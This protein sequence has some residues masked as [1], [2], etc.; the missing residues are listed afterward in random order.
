MLDQSLSTTQDDSIFDPDSRAQTLAQLAEAAA[1]SGDHNQAEALTEQITDPG[2]RARTLAQLAETATISG[3]HNRAARLASKAEALAEQLADPR[4][5]A[6][7][8]AQLAGTLV[9]T[10][11][12]TSPAPGHASSRSP[13]MVRA[14]H[15]LAAAL[16]TGSW[17]E[18]IA[19]LAR[20]DPLAVTALADELQVRWEPNPHGTRDGRGR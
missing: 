6:Q 11:E 9:E 10:S 8:L 12:K 14:R 15:L 3:D 1:A 5:R 17:T 16:V 4:L 18:V 19:S 2:R 20:M 13:L 7:A